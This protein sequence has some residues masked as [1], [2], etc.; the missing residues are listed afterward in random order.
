MIN[1]YN[2]IVMNNVN[3]EKESSGEMMASMKI[4]HRTENTIMA[5]ECVCVSMAGMWP[6]SIMTIMK[7]INVGNEREWNE[8]S[9][10]FKIDRKIM[11]SNNVMAKA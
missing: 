11:K 9:E 3:N 4:K 7:K 1:S 8:I 2:E 10:I 6:I 5:G